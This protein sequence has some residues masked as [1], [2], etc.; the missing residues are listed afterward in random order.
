MKS[1][2]EL[3]SGTLPIFRLFTG[4]QLAFTGLSL[5]TQQLMLFQPHSNSITLSPLNLLEPG[6]L[7]LYLSIPN[8]KRALK[9]LYLPIGIVMAATGLV[10]DSFVAGDISSVWLWR[11]TLFLCIPLY[12][13]SLQYSMRQVI[14]FC[15]LTTV[16]NLIMLSFSETFSNSP[17]TI[18]L[19][20][21]ILFL[22]VGNMVVR[23]IKVQK[24]QWQQLTEA[25]ER[26]A[27]HALTVEQL[28][29]SRERNRVAR[30]LH[31]ILA[32]TL[33]GVAVEMEGL[34]AVMHRDPEQANTLLNHSLQAIRDGLTETRRAL[35]ELRAKPLEDLGLALAMKSLTDSV[36]DR[37]GTKIDVTMDNNLG[38]LSTEVEQCIYR[39]AQEALT[40]IADHA[41]ANRAQLI[42]QRD[43]AQINLV[44][45][46]DGC[47]FN[48]NA[49]DED[50]KFGLR[51][52]RERAEMVGGHL[53][54]ESQVGKGTKIVFSHGVN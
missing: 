52:M 6:L 19:I 35:H 1:I 5:I 12:V 47:G 45:T 23:L 30:E 10:I 3:E 14:L 39:I 31:D 15:T 46:D 26:L 29:I 54:I 7:L 53:S 16:L 20:Q 42:L 21:L 13:V 32:H 41:L 36:A 27:Q 9:T 34:R 50:N 24:D 18:I 51:G 43:G 49:L 28:T 33:S 37:I 17:L 11:Q 48:P 2:Q 44:I 25:N 38:E 4:L 40:N 22:L 8:L